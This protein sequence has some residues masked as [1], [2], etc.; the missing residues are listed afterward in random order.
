MGAIL[1]VRVGKAVSCQ[2]WVGWSILTDDIGSWLLPSILGWNV[3]DFMVTD[4][5]C[6]D[7]SFLNYFGLLEFPCVG[8]WFPASFRWFFVVHHFDFQ[9]CLVSQFV[10]Y[11]VV[12]GFFGSIMLYR[13]VLRIIFA[14]VSV[15]G[16]DW[17]RGEKAGTSRS[18]VIFFIT[19]VFFFHWCTCQ[20]WISLEAWSSLFLLMFLLSARLR[21]WIL[22][23]SFAYVEL[24][25][26]VL[27]EFQLL[28]CWFVSLA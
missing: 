16:G 12:L 21:C 25:G 7:F 1:D 8:R 2:Q 3:V 28:W 19:I 9:L 6:P 27:L 11:L 17:G 10:Y 5:V 4:F 13:L 26:W 20:R 24:T 15:F 23:Q 14:L 18:F 22:S